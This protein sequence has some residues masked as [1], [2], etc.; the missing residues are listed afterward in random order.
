M[1]LLPA[2]V[3]VF[4]NSQQGTDV[5]GLPWVRTLL[6]AFGRLSGY[7]EDGARGRIV[8]WCGFALFLA[9]V[10]GMTLLDVRHDDLE[11]LP[12]GSSIRQ[13]MRQVDEALGG[14]AVAEL[15]LQ[16]ESDRMRKPDV[17]VA[18]EKLAE[19]T[20][21]PSDANLEQAKSSSVTEVLRTLHQLFSGDNEAQMPE[22]QASLSQL[23]VLFF[24]NQG[25]DTVKRWVTTDWSETRLSFRLKLARSDAYGPFIEKLEL[26]AQKRVPKDIDFVLTGFAVIA[27]QLVTTLLSDLIVSFCAAFA[28]VTIL[29]LVMLKDVRLGLVAMLPNLLPIFLVLGGMG[30]TDIPIDLNSLLVS[31]MALGIAVDDTMHFLFHFKNTSKKRMTSRR[32]SGLP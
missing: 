17:L 12:K 21:K 20:T 32:A 11:F 31:S 7:K 14:S 22:D 10:A 29:M 30:V 15:V 9:S 19:I 16:G 18:I 3:L 2:I 23:Q 25:P 13:S 27:F 28:F 24:E 8:L 1:T 26:T 6:N 4:G 5:S